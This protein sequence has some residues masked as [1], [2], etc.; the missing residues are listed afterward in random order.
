MSLKFRNAN[1]IAL[2]MRIINENTF[3]RYADLFRT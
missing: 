1:N 3:M 2:E